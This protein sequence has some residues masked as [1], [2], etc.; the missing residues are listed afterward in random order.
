MPQINIMQ[1]YTY[2]IHSGYIN[3]SQAKVLKTGVCKMR[4]H[5]SAEIV[6]HCLA[7]KDKNY[8]SK[9]ETGTGNMEMQ[10]Y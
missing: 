3:N 8:F 4:I 2:T 1:L 9:Y 10:R 7:G 6:G 5:V